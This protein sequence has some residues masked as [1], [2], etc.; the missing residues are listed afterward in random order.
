MILERRFLR[1]SF[2]ILGACA[3][4]VLLQGAVAQVSRHPLGAAQ[5]AHAATSPALAAPPTG[6]VLGDMTAGLMWDNPAGTTQNQLQVFPANNDGPGINI[7]MNADDGFVIPAPPQWYGLLPGMTYTWHVRATDTTVGLDESSDLWGPWSADST[8]R[9]PDATAGSVNLVSPPDRTTSG[10]ARP[11]LQWRDTNSRVFYYEL[12]LSKDPTFNNDP[13]TATA[14]VYWLLLHGGINIPTNSYR[15]PAGAEL[16][17]A[18]TYYWRVRPRIQGD[19]QPAAWGSSSSFYVQSTTMPDLDGNRIIGGTVSLERMT[20][21]AGTTFLVNGPVDIAGTL[22]A[23]GADVTV[24]ADGAIAVAGAITT[25]R[26]T[27]GSVDSP[28]GASITLKSQATITIIGSLTTGSGTST[29]ASISAVSSVGHI[30]AASAGSAGNGGSVVLSAPNAVAI[31]PG[32]TIATGDGAGG[33][34]AGAQAPRGTST[35]AAAGGKGGDAGSVTIRSGS[36]TL[37]ESGIVFTLGNGGNGGTAIVTADASNSSDRAGLTSTGGAGGDGGIVDIFPE[38]PFGSLSILVTGGAAGNGGDAKLV[39]TSGGVSAARSMGVTPINRLTDNPGDGGASTTVGGNGGRTWVQT[40]GNGGNATSMPGG[41]AQEGA[42]GTGG[43]SR[44]AGGRGG[45]SVY[46][47]GGDGGMAT[48]DAGGK[49]G[50]GPNGGAGGASIAVGG[51]GGYG[52]LRFGRGGSATSALGGIGGR[53]VQCPGGIGGPGGQS[54][55]RGGNGNPGATGFASKGGWAG[56]GAYCCSLIP[57]VAGGPGGEGGA[58]SGFG[59]HGRTLSLNPLVSSANGGAAF[60]LGGGDGGHGGDGLTAGSGGTGGS[61]TT[62]AGSGAS[63][64]NGGATTAGPRGLRGGD[65]VACPLPTSTRT[66]TPTPPST[67]GGETPTPTVT[68]SPSPTATP[69]M[70]ATPTPTVTPT[71]VPGNRAPTLNT[72]RAEFLPSPH[73]TS[74]QVTASDPDGDTISYHWELVAPCGVLAEED[75]G[76]TM[77]YYHGECTGPQEA[78]ATIRITISDGRGG[79]DTYIQA[80][81]ANEGSTINVP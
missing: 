26:V 13:A 22:A 4:A 72:F 29:P 79:S 74:Y 31:Q 36:L 71:P 16:E 37:P 23:E 42:A 59:G 41:W 77:H 25:A 47:Y 2:L 35:S 61:V 51:H 76:P 60:T 70:T 52:P 18:T 12:Q 33:A 65:G 9:T 28:N 68:G 45:S 8:F 43:V 3:F 54:F 50:D 19:G 32:A 21:A 63:G 69:T 53:A 14:S 6:S 17:E 5:L 34:S 81:R 73:M 64:G 80:A 75:G 27:S 67:G 49:G 66:P 1:V 40:G 48:A 46:G 44:A 78:Q 38:Q 20:I 30:L 57:P 58:S 55:A 39:P 24:E 10:T 62:T 56:P 7:I 11:V 15:V